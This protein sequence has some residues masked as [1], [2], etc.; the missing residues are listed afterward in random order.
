MIRESEAERSKYKFLMVNSFIC[1]GYALFNHYIGAFLK[2]SGMKAIQIGT[3]MSIGPIATIIIQPLWAK[4]SDI[5]G[6]RTTVLAIVALGSACS[7][8]YFYLGNSYYFYASAMA[9]YFSFGAALTPLSDAIIIKKSKKIGIDFSRIRIGGTVGAAVIT[10]IAGFYLKS[11]PSAMFSLATISYLILML[12]ILSMPKEE[13]EFSAKV[14]VSRIAFDK[15]RNEKIFNSREAYLVL[16]LACISTFGLTFIN[17]FLGVYVLELGYNQSLIGILNFISAMSEVP[18]L[19]WIVPLLNSYNPIA[20]MII[21][22]I[23]TGLRVFLAAEG[24]I[25]T[26][27]IAQL[28]QGFTFMMMYFSCATYV[29][30]HVNSNKESQGQSILVMFQSGIGA[31]LGNILGGKLVDLV[32]IKQTYRFAAIFIIIVII[33]TGI[34]YMDYS[35]KNKHLQ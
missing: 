11:N 7:C 23:L 14:D 10:L 27:L 3:L 17:S 29:S 5:S 31:I 33:I 20:I 13:N 32:G 24:T 9:L 2:N 18:I 25:I 34:I 15:K 4:L 21:A 30:N 35:R 28:M 16:F 12:F 19:L 8:S 26:L 22:S 6:K 1:I